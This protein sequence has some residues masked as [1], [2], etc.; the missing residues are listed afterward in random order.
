MLYLQ[1]LIVNNATGD[2]HLANRASGDKVTVVVVRNGKRVDIPLELG[3]H[4]ESLAAR[5][6]EEVVLEPVAKAKRRARSI[7]EAIFGTHLK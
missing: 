4:G 1:G 7:R 6:V 3:G 2:A 5:Q